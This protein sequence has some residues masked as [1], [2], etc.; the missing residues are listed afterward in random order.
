M[1]LWQTP[2]SD[3][4]MNEITRPDRCILCLSIPADYVEFAA[5][6][7]NSDFVARNY[8]ANFAASTVESIYDA[9]YAELAR[10]ISATVGEVRECG[11]EVK[12]SFALSDL[13]AIAPYDVATIV[14]HWVEAE[15]KIELSDGR[16]TPEQFAEN[17]PS[18][19][20]GLLDLTICQSA[21]LIDCVKSRHPGCLV[22]A[23][24]KNAHVDFRLILYKAIIR[25]L[26]VTEMSYMDAY[27]YS[28]K[29]LIQHY[30]L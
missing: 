18:G 13:P 5:S 15:G 8:V 12:T 11:T 21:R 24:L 17:I 2:A 10:I 3:F 27:T 26:R 7:G 1:E 29:H 4:A 25:L 20:S 30:K 9:H 23:N 6:V 16:Y 14:A 19:Y 28:I 22:L